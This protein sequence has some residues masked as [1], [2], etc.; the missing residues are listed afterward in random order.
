M[1]DVTRKFVYADGIAFRDYTF[2]DNGTAT[3][4]GEYPLEGEGT[5]LEGSVE[6]IERDMNLFV[7]IGYEEVLS[8]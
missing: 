2:H 6:A 8:E 3:V 7:S 1:T 5:Y 4:T